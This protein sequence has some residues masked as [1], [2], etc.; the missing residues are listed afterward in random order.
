MKNPAPSIRKAMYNLLNGTITYNTEVI[1]VYEGE[2]EQVPKSIIIGGYSHQDDSGKGFFKYRASQLVE[3]I[4]IGLGFNPT[5]DSDQIAQLVIDVIKPNTRM[6]ENL[7]DADFQVMIIGGPDMDPI[8][9]ESTEGGK[10]VRRLLRY[11]LIVV[12][13]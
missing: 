4:T 8:R 2:G 7:S 1:P 5:K 6:S 11:N 9:E 3:I 13:R 12:E 10:V